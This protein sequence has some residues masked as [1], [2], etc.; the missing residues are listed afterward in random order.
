MK[1]IQILVV[2]CNEGILE[3]VVRLINKN[4]EWEAFGANSEQQARMFFEQ[5]SYDLVLF[6]G[7]VAPDIERN[8]RLL[9]V[10]Q[11]PAIKIV[12]HW[13]GGSGLLS[14]EII[15]ALENNQDGIFNLV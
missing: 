13:G 4:A 11:N 2:G 9:F 12:Q 1:K 6:G 7:G 3:T 15:A 14:N 5:K 10:V 8:L